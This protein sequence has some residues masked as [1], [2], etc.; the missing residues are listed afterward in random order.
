MRLKDGTTY[1][2]DPDFMREMM[3]CYP[4]V[5]INEQ[6]QK[7]RAWLLSNPGK[8]KTRRGMPRFINSWLSR[9]PKRERSFIE[10]QTDRS[11][12]EGL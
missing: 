11:W 1:T 10:R 7:M 5:D 2:P 6:L 3:D 9:S 12:A 4:D 8:R